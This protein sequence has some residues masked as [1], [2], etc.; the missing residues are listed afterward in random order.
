MTA[1]GGTRPDPD[2]EAAGGSEYGN[3]TGFATAATGNSAG[4]SAGDSGGAGGAGSEAAG[5]PEPAGA[6]ATGELAEDA[7][8]TDPGR[9]AD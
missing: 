3:D 1:P 4:N 9:G 8:D 6:E 2:S 5:S 7:D